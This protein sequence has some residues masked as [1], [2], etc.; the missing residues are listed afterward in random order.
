MILG[1]L[2]A[3]SFTNW[4]W[5]RSKKAYLLLIPFEYLYKMIVS[6]KQ[7]KERAQAKPFP[8]PVVVVGNITVGG[9]GKSPVVIALVSYLRTQGYSP[10]IVSRGYG[11][12]RPDR[13]QPLPV[14]PNSDPCRVGDEPVMIAAATGCPVV[15]ASDRVRAVNE[16][17]AIYPE[18]NIVISD[19]GLQHYRLWWDVAICVVDAQRRFGNEHCLPAGP[20]REPVT[21]LHDMDFVITTGSVDADVVLK[22]QAWVSLG[23]AEEEALDFFSG[24]TVHAVAGIAHPER[25]FET[26]R[27]QHIQ[28][29]PH[30]FP[31]HY[32]FSKKDLMFDDECPVV[33]TQKDAVKCKNFFK[34][35][36][37]KVG[38][39]RMQ[40]ELSVSFKENIIKAILPFK[41]NNT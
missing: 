16:L 20:L 6:L 31:D 28:V 22:P 15:V 13:A 26:L 24:K 32:F 9:T 40:A 34:S 10:G 11:G 35:D 18:C 27:S 7:K 2:S 4:L 1:S 25:F 21:A 23:H 39:L 8:V 41:K 38:Y 12:K 14:T 33:M 30:A 29:I 17:L 3:T 5:Y 19:D 36:D 37:V